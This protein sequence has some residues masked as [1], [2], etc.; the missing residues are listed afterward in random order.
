[1]R[2]PAKAY[3]VANSEYDVSGEI[4]VKIDQSDP[5]QLID[6]PTGAYYA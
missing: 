5:R 6:A 1:M 2:L 3:A 4:V